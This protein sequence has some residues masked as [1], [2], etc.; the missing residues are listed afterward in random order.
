VFVRAAQARWL[1]VRDQG[2]GRGDGA[3]SAAMQPP[4]KRPIA[5]TTTLLKRVVTR[6]HSSV[7]ISPSATLRC[8]TAEAIVDWVR[9]DLVGLTTGLGPSWPG[10]TIWIPSSAADKIVLWGPN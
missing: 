4:V 9:E 1:Q 7:E 6:D 10:S 5:A 8:E 3:V 2:G